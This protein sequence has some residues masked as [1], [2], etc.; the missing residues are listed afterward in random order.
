MTPFD[1]AGKHFPQLPSW[2]MQL[3]LTVCLAT[4]AFLA[5][6]RQGIGAVEIRAH[7]APPGEPL[8][9]GFKVAVGKLD[10]PVYV[11]KVGFGRPRPAL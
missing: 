9:A 2:P 7:P 1:L 8:S 11:A 3:R 4:I 5:F 6:S 10:V